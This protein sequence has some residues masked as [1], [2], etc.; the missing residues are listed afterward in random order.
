MTTFKAAILNT[1]IVFNKYMRSM[2]NI[3]AWIQS[4]FLCITLTFF[5]GGD[6]KAAY[7]QIESALLEVKDNEP[8]FAKTVSRIL[9]ICDKEEKTITLYKILKN[10]KNIYPSN[11]L[12]WLINN[13]GVGESDK[14]DIRDLFQR[15]VLTVLFKLDPKYSWLQSLR[16]NFELRKK[17]FSSIDAMEVMREIAFFVEM[18]SESKQGSNSEK[19]GKPNPQTNKST[20]QTASNEILL[21][22]LFGELVTLAQN[23]GA[24]GAEIIKLYNTSVPEDKQLPIPQ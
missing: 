5:A 6:R 23:T 16:I 17:F 18:N 21:K 11:S 7:R 19:N 13:I 9:A 1:Q 12:S 15:E 14:I 22:Q 2:I 20:D 8:V 10:I 24:P 4:I 3:K